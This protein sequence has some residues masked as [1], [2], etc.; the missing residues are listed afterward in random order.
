MINVVPMNE[1]KALVVFSYL[2][3]HKSEAEAELGDIL[4]AEGH[5]LKYLISKTLLKRGEN[6]V[7]NPD[8]FDSWSDEK[9]ETISEYFVST[10]FDSGNEKDCEHFYLF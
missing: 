5:Y 3:E 10:M 7:I 4:V 9:K 2:N 8:Y 1:Y 6:F